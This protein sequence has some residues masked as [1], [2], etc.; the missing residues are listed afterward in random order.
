M[1]VDAGCATVTLALAEL[2]AA[3]ASTAELLLMLAVSVVLCRQESTG[4]WK[5]PG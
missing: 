3:L 1:L 4:W 5:P 2:L